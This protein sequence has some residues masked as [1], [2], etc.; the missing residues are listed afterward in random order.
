MLS[1]ASFG[2]MLNTGSGI[3]G[4]CGIAGGGGDA[5]CGAAG[6]G[7][8]A[9]GGAAGGPP[10]EPPAVTG[11]R[12]TCLQCGQRTCL[13]R[14]SIPTPIRRPQKGHGNVC[15]CDDIGVDIMGPDPSPRVGREVEY[16]LREVVSYLVFWQ[17]PERS[18]RDFER[19]VRT[20]SEFAESSVLITPV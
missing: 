10:G 6:G 5:I 3:G 18:S 2:K 12:T 11:A 16:G 20:P 14:R 7:G 8:T 13:P 4:M 9:T 17:T 15:V 19:I 1:A